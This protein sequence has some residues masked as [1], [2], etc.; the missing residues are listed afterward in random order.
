M[1]KKLTFILFVFICLSATNLYSY[2]KANEYFQPYEGKTYPNDE[3]VKNL[4]IEK[5]VLPKNT[6]KIDTKKEFDAKNTM[7][8]WLIMDRKDKVELIDSL[9]G[10]FKEKEGVIISKPASYYID[11]INGVIYNG[12][13]NGDIIDFKNRGIGNIFKTIAVMDGDFNNGKDKIETFK[14]M[15]GD[16][17]LEAYK[18]QHPDKYRALL[19]IRQETIAKLNGK[20]E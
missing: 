2:N 6:E 10:I 11:E 9:K 7:T 14:E 16:K 5:G 1:N 8:L 4:A 13:N 15:L 20:H 19:K 18:T 12:L 17:A 3:A